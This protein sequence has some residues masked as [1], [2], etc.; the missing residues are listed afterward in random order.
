MA[1]ANSYGLTP[2]LG[3]SVDDKDVHN[4]HQLISSELDFTPSVTSVEEL[5]TRPASLNERCLTS[6]SCLKG[7]A[8]TAGSEKLITGVLSAQGTDFGLDLVLYDVGS[9][10]IERRKQFTLPRD[11]TSLANGM[12]QVVRELLTGSGASETAVVAAGGGG[13]FDD[14]PEDDF[15]FEGSDPAAEAAALA[16]A[17]LAAAQAAQRAAAEEAARL[18]AAEELRRQEEFARAEAARQEQERQRREREAALAAAAA[19]AVPA[20]SAASVDDEAAMISFGSA[21]GMSAEEVDM[22]I[23][24]GAPAPAPAPLPTPISSPGGLSAAEAAYEEAALEAASQPREPVRAEKN[25]QARAPRTQAERPEQV[26]S[27][28]PGAQ[29]LQITARAGYAKYYAFDFLTAGGELG[30]P[31]IAGLHLLAGAEMY[32]VQRILPEDL[33]VLTGLASEWNTIFPMNLGLMYKFTGN[34]VQPYVGADTIMVQYYRD[35][36]GSDWAVGGRLRGGAD[37]MLT[38]SFGFNVNIAMGGWNGRNWY[39]IEDTVQNSGFLPQ[40]S[41]G[42]VVSF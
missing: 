16:A 39:L 25:N 1:W 21:E 41:A 24:F 6:T 26:S 33:A 15:E 2:L 27:D 29:N 4:I 34:T 13:E 30:V 12:T 9:N 42:T 18:A 8:T 37:F 40:V 7:I 35:E 14:I 20:V 22:L 5:S 10:Q 32:A 11:P 28:R 38:K 31:V 36:I 19:A 3:S 23:Q 17:Q